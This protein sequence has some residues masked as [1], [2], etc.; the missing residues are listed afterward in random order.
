MIVGRSLAFEKGGARTRRRGGA[1]VTVLCTTTTTS[2]ALSSP[3]PVAGASLTLPST[4]STGVPLEG[5]FSR[6]GGSRMEVPA[7][8]NDVSSRE[9]AKWEARGDGPESLTL[10]EQ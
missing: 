3:S 5:G 10:A 2:A 6:G 7:A 8:P 9:R 4:S 1:Q